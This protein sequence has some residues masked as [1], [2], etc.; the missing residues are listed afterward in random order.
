MSNRNVYRPSEELVKYMSEILQLEIQ[1]TGKRNAEIPRTSNRKSRRKNYY[2]NKYV[3]PS[4]ANVVV[5]LECAS[6]I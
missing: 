2:L 4:M 1:H 6:R 3:F 5:F